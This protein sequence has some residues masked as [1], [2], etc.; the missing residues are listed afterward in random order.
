MQLERTK[1][2]AIKK[3]SENVTLKEGGGHYCASLYILR[4]MECI[5]GLHLV[6]RHNASNI[7]DK[8]RNAI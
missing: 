5:H 7:R 3:M 4:L 1:K 8:M 2:M 6:N